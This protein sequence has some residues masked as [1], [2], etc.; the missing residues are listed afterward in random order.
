MGC[1]QDN[2]QQTLK[3]IDFFS[4]SELMFI[5]FHLYKRVTTP[6]PNFT[7]DKTWYVCIKVRSHLVLGTLVFESINTILVI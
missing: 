3:Q 4:S 1:P 7:E 2:W 5:F 6:P